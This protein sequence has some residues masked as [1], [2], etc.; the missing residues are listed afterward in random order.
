MH[1]LQ[2]FPATTT[3]RLNVAGLLL[4]AAGM[5]LQIAAGSDLYPTFTGPIVLL[6]TAVTVTVWSGR[7]T[8]YVGLLVP[9]ALGLGAIIAA[10]MTGEFVDQ[11]TGVDQPGVLTGSAVHVIGLTA[12]ISGGVG[13]LLDRPAQ[14][15]TSVASQ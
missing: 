12:A 1:D 14:R 5:L 3:A 9:L 10:A 15:A 11:L 8:T 7:W 2:A 4:T 6:V 13:M